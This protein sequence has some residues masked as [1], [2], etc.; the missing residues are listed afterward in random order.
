[1]ITQTQ[2]LVAALGSQQPLLWSPVATPQV[3][4]SEH[5][6]AKLLSAQPSVQTLEA[7]LSALSYR[8]PDDRSKNEPKNTDRFSPPIAPAF[9]RREDCF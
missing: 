3:L 5:S 8:T 6:E 9:H 7:S 1:M 2:N 4:G